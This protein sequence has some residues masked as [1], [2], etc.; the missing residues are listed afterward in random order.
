MRL[1]FLAVM[2]FGA[3]ACAPV[4]SVTRRHTTGQPPTYQVGFQSGC[5]SGY[6]AAG[7]PYARFGKDVAAYTSD[8]L[9]KS[10]WDDGFAVCKGDY[11]SI[12]NA[13]RR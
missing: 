10:G 5:G 2:A 6:V 11:E 1:Y 3:V 9:Y 8:A 7:N 12:G 13:L 4:D